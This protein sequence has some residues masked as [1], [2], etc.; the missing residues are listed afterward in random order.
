[1]RTF[2]HCQFTVSTVPEFLIPQSSVRQADGESA[3][4]LHEGVGV[5]IA[6]RLKLERARMG[7]KQAEFAE[8]M[9]V[10]KT[11]QHNYEAGDRNE[12]G[13]DKARVPDAEYL[14]RAHELGL[15][16]HYV[17]TGQR[18]VTTEDFVVIPRYDVAASAGGGALNGGA[19]RL[20]GLSF[21]RLWL[22]KRGLA[23]NNLQVV[24]VAGDSMAGRLND[25]DQVLM[26]TAETLPK[27]GRAY[28][29]LQEDELLVKYCQLLP[30][31]VLRVSSEN[32][33]YP[34]YDIDLQKTDKVR[35]L[36]RV[37]ASTHEW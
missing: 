20:P 3:E 4:Q 1:M 8:K 28:V 21:S 26:N 9:G 17:I 32:P 19:A 6:E 7:Y 2:L 34:P 13:K 31:G 25:G 37:V 29:L 11:T 27:S 16:I 12:V 24:D 35:I 30:G 14:R 36:G 18:L 10:S 33:H 5:D 23:P 22:N 15:D